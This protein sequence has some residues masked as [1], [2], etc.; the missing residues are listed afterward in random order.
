MSIHKQNL[1]NNNGTNNNNNDV[2][3]NS[4]HI[5]RSNHN[6]MNKSGIFLGSSLVGMKMDI[7]DNDDKICESLF[8][9]M[10]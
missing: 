4:L 2:G 5:F 6:I 10:K 1:H 7:R 9:N 8:L 3:V